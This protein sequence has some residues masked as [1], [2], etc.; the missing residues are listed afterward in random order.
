MFLLDTNVVSEPFAKQPEPEILVW[1]ERHQK[2]GFVIS[3]IVKA[4]IEYGINNMPTGRKRNVLARDM[5]DF[6]NSYMKLCLPFDGE[7]ATY[8][9]EIRVAQK[10]AGRDTKKGNNDRDAMTAAIAMQHNLT[11]ATRNTKD[12]ADVKNLKTINPWK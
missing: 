3:A 9:A 1:M 2:E 10:R 6:I 4:E 8:Y 11:L 5:H 12:F 7:S